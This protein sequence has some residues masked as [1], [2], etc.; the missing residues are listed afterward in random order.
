M[1]SKKSSVRYDV[2]A[3]AEKVLQ[4]NLKLA[5]IEQ[6]PSRLEID[7]KVYVTVR[8]GFTASH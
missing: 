2:D 3:T 5:M 6:R 1:R 7:E 8:T 4:I